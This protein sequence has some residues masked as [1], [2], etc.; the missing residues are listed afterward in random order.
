MRVGLMSTDFDAFYHAH[1]GDAVRW[2][3]GLVGNREVGEEIAQEAM[4]AVCQRLGTLDSPAAYLRRTVVNRSISW[5]RW[6]RG[7]HRRL[8]RAAAGEATSYTSPTND[9]LS[10]LES[11]TSRQRTAVVLRYWSDWTDD[12]IGESLG[13]APATVRV[14]LHRG[15]AALKKEITL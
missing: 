7:E 14:L 3:A 2:A 1:I 5:H 11:L 9:M 4:F 13:C 15:L 12:Q 8:L 10:A 6:H